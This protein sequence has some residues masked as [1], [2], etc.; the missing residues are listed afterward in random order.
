MA[1]YQIEWKSSSFKELKRLDRKVIQRIVSAVESLSSDP[2]PAG[3]RK[4]RGSERSYRI[5]VG[6]Y[7]IVYEINDDRL[8]II[9]IR[10][11]H[12]KDVYR[13]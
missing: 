7:R 2:R 1:T 12:R 10:V 3:V 8:I 11:R 4:L 5:R 6:E 9:V 13:N